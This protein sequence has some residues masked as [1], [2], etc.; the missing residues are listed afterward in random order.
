MLC[1]E[2]K[3][4]RGYYFDGKGNYIK[5]TASGTSEGEYTIHES[6]DENDSSVTVY[7][8][9]I[10]PK[11]TS[12]SAIAG[13]EVFYLAVDGTITCREWVTDTEKVKIPFTEVD[14]SAFYSAFK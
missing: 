4:P 10:I 5:V 6:V 14:E 2:G 3:E 13:T 1:Q 7:G 9:S 12:G 11:T 8:I